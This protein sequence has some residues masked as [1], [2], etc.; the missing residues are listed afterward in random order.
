MSNSPN[1]FLFQKQKKK[2]RI[3]NVIRIVTLNSVHFKFI[4]ITVKYGLSAPLAQREVTDSSM[5]SKNAI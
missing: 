5:K 3:I 2:E 4:W 1:L